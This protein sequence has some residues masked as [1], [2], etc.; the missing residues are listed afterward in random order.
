MRANLLTKCMNERHAQ[1]T[2][3]AKEKIVKH[4]RFY[5]APYLVVPH[6]ILKCLQEKMMS[7][8]ML[9]IARLLG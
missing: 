1:L 4:S 8:Q 6:Y 2:K 7:H 9:D 5:R 3:G